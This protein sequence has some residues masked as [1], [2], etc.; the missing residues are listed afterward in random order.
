[1]GVETDLAIKAVGL[2]KQF[3]EVVALD[4]LD[5]AVPR[6]SIFGFLGP[7]GSGKTTAMRILLGL[8]V[9]TAGRATVL[10]H[11]VVRDSI[12]SR[13]RVGYLAQKPAFYDELNSRETLRFARGFFPLDPDRSVE[14]EI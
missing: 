10:G 9:R 14:A 1:M 2:T 5:L 3:G 8:V 12:E 4:H 11:D 6:H 7:N 13:R